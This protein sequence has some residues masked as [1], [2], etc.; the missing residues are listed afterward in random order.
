MLLKKEIER[1]F[2]LADGVNLADI[3]NKVDSYEW[4]FIQDIYLCKNVRLRYSNLDGFKLTIKFGSGLLRYEYEVSLP[5]FIY[6]YFFGRFKTLCK[7][8]SS[9]LYNNN[10]YELNDFL[11]DLV[12][13]E[14]EFL[15]KESAENITLPYWVGRDVTNDRNFNGYYLFKKYSE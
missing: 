5:E 9:I 1:R 2:L 15:D 6:K 7:A 12:T 11:Y 8:R 10:I 3:L 13:I 14:V 4:Q